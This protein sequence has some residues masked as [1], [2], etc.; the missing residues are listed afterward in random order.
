M[1]VTVAM[2]KSYWIVAALVC[3]A[4]LVKAQTSQ[5]P[6]PTPAAGQSGLSP[7][8]SNGSGAQLSTGTV[9]EYKPG[10]R[11]GIR[12]SKNDVVTL[13]LDKNVRVDGLVEEGQLAAVMWMA[14]GNSRR[15]TSITAAPG[16]GNAGTADLA[17]SYQKMSEPTPGAKSPATPGTTPAGGPNILTPG[18]TTPRSTPRAAT[19]TPKP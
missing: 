6:K 7:S 10:Q 19:P 1:E 2:K 17:S 15:V 11:I 18:S 3:A 8:M 5:A 14:D 12:V 4:G 16:P 13:D 9:V